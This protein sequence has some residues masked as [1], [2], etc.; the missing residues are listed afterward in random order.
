M[1]LYEFEHFSTAEY[2]KSCSRVVS[3]HITEFFGLEGTLKIILFDL[4]VKG[5]GIFH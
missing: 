4:L 3:L 5:K 2:Y 1:C